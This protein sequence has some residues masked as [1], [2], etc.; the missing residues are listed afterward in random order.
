MTAAT[1]TTHPTA[2]TPGKPAAAR[3]TAAHKSAHRAAQMAA[4]GAT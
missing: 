3:V 1:A 4:D 2:A